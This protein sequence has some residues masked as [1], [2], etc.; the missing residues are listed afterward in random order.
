M[1]DFKEQV[2][3]NELKISYH[4]KKV[5]SKKPTALY[6]LITLY[7]KQ[8]KIMT[9]VRVYGEHWND[10]KQKAYVSDILTE[11]DNRNNV[12]VNKR[13]SECSICFEEFKQY[14]CD[15]PDAYNKEAIHI[16]RSK[17][18]G[19]KYMAKNKINPF[20]YLKREIE[21]DNNIGESSKAGY[22]GKIK[23]L[24]DY[25]KENSINI[26]TLQD[27]DAKLLLQY[28]DWMLKQ[29]KSK[30]STKLVSV[31]TVNEKMSVIISRLY[32]AEK[33]EKYDTS[34]AKLNTIEHIKTK[35]DSFEDKV[36]LTEEE[37][38]RINNL[39]IKDKDV[40]LIR[41]TFVSQ[42]YMGQR[43]SDM[44]DFSDN[45]V[46]TTERGKDIFKLIQKK[47]KTS[48]SIPIFDITKSILEKNDWNIGYKDDPDLINSTI[49]KICKKAGLNE[50]ILIRREDAKGVHT[51][52]V[53]K[54]QVVTSHT[55]RR[56]FV[57]IASKR[58]YSADKVS[59]ITGHRKMEVLEMYNRMSSSDAAIILM[60]DWDNKDNKNKTV[61]DKSNTANIQSVV[62]NM[63]E[64]LEKA[65]QDA[66]EAQIKEDK[67]ALALLGAD[68]LEIADANT[69]DTIQQL[70]CKYQ[71]QYTDMGVDPYAIKAIFHNS[72]YT[73]F[74]EKR[75]QLEKIVEEL[76]K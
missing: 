56:T 25:C 26:V 46:K 6:M 41:D 70:I 38:E 13:L 57:T 63:T 5:S 74:A 30:N 1:N 66:F 20:L 18:Y 69:I 33:K 35:V 23:G 28:R 9:G 4:K 44:V 11:N 52:Q 58:G 29:T 3:I 27:I 61:K 53:E 31:K 49:R 47:G 24:E 60:D 73:T 22:V 51:E 15:N 65:K 16:L 68:A 32:E 71:Q 42:C 72:Q 40:A 48:V 64:V 17:I 67:N 8:Y 62:C 12:I 54:W 7:G 14:L 59:R 45:A 75:K 2:F 34:K 21:K 19:E 55:A 76:K 37:I 36:A 39:E 10:R 50:T 43:Y